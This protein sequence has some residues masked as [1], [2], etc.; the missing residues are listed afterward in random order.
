MKIAWCHYGNILDLYTWEDFIIAFRHWHSKYLIVLS[1][2]VSWYRDTF[3]I[4]HQYSCTLYRLISS[5]KWLR[6]E[7]DNCFHFHHP[8]T[9]ILQKCSCTWGFYF[10][11]VIKLMVFS[12]VIH[13]LFY[14]LMM[15]TIKFRYTM[16]I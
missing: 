6:K 13:I 14:R 15:S 1:S 3:G 5:T 2:D 7:L 16:D 4:M 8:L 12:V 11:K 9:S 10:C